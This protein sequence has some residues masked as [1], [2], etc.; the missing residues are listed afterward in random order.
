MY[1][2]HWL[3]TTTYICTY[4][5]TSVRWHASLDANSS[6]AHHHLRRL[7][8]RSEVGQ[9][10]HTTARISA[11]QFTKANNN[12]PVPDST[13]MVVGMTLSKAQAA[14]MALLQAVDRK[15]TEQCQRSRSR[16]GSEAASEWCRRASDLPDVIGHWADG[17]GADNSY[18]PPFASHLG[19]VHGVA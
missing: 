11:L 16:D 5:P 13:D 14:S 19:H 18:G 6:L 7:V 3:V 1:Q 17:L 12:T 9:G 2:V 8:D 4:L 15:E 10:Q